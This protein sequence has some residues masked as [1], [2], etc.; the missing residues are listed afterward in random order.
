MKLSSSV[1]WNRARNQPSKTKRHYGELGAYATYAAFWLTPTGLTCIRKMTTNV[2]STNQVGPFWI[3]FVNTYFCES[4]TQ[5]STQTETQASNHTKTKTPT[6]AQNHGDMQAHTQ[7]HTHAQTLGEC[8]G[9]DLGLGF[10]KRQVFTKMIQNHL[11][12][13]LHIC[14]H[15][16]DAR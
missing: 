11:I 10:T 14:S 6:S 5:T 4:Q 7:V 9:P 1:S 8:L 2:Q 13:W 3:S 16:S 12:G 15:F